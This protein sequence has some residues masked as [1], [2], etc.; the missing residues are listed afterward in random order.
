[1][2]R[3]NTRFWNNS[4]KKNTRNWKHSIC[5]KK[6]TLLEGRGQGGDG[7]QPRLQKK[8][9]EI[10]TLLLYHFDQL[11]CVVTCDQLDEI[12]VSSF[13]YC[14]HDVPKFLS[15][16]WVALGTIYI[17]LYEKFFGQKVKIPT[18]KTILSF[19]LLLYSFNQFVSH[20]SH[21]IF[22]IPDLIF[23]LN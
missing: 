21:Q 1:M 14:S 6:H 17:I 18:S 23:F 4:Q 5:G 11:V 16:L 22:F 19:S 12:L 9:D 10:Q 20:M 2:I 13:G 8:L 15:E 3:I 7:F